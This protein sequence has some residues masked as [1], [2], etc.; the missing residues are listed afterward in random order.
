VIALSQKGTRTVPLVNVR[1]NPETFHEVDNLRLACEEIIPAGFYSPA[2]Q[3][4]PGSIE[5]FAIPRGPHDGMSTD[6]FID[7]EAQFYEDRTNVTK[8]G[9]AIADALKEIF[10]GTTFAIWPKLVIAGWVSDS[11]DQDSDV[12]MSMEAA[13]KRASWLIEIRTTS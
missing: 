6:V 5:F 4:S 10:P 1:Y 3:L 8:R 12:D 2:G 11:V 13:L 9:Q 7:I